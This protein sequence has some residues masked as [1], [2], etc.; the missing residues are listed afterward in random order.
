MELKDI[1]FW[2]NEYLNQIEYL[3]K[4]DMKKMFD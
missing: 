4:I 3:L 2:E 1:E